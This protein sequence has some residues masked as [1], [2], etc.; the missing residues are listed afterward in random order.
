MTHWNQQTRSA[1]FEIAGNKQRATIPKTLAC[2]RNG[3]LS[4][5]IAGTLVLVNT[6]ACWLTDASA[7]VRCKAGLAVCPWVRKG[8]GQ[9]EEAAAQRRDVR[10]AA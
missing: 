3:C 4:C 6:G 7:G 1:N 5:V 8:C 9:R 2:P 10:D